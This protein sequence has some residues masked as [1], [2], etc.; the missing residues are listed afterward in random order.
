MQ[1]QVVKCAEVVA[2]LFVRARAAV[3]WTNRTNREQDVGDSREERRTK[4][5]ADVLSGDVRVLVHR[6]AVCN[7]RAR[8]EV[9][10]LV[11]TVALRVFVGLRLDHGP[12][13]SVGE[14]SVCRVGWGGRESRRRSRV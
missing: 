3:W 11:C 1:V 2:S 7:V 4:R 6:P 5:W 9:C 8:C 13:V 12:L 14:W 10:A